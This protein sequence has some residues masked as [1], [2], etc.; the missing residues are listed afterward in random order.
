MTNA[1]NA[2]IAQ[3]G[4]NLCNLWHGLK[5]Q[6]TQMRNQER[7]G[8]VIARPKAVAI[9]AGFG[10]RYAVRESPITQRQVFVIQPVLPPLH[11]SR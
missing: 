3:T 11:N 10:L 7:P 4:F 8:I 5:P 1:R 9:H 2:N 6:M